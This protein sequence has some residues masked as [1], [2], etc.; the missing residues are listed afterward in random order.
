ME[1]PVD[2]QHIDSKDIQTMRQLETST[3]DQLVELVPGQK[4][5]CQVTTYIDSLES[6]NVEGSLISTGTMFSVTAIESIEILSFEFSHS[7]VDGD[8][9]IEIYTLA[10]SDYKSQR[11]NKDAWKLLSATGMKGVP[12]SDKGEKWKIAPRAEMKESVV[13]ASGETRSFY[14][15][16]LS[17]HLLLM[18]NKLTNSVYKED[19]KLRVNSG[20]GV[21]A[22][23][24][25]D[26]TDDDN[27]AFQGRI[28]YR[29]TA[30]CTTLTQTTTKVQVPF[31]V[32]STAVPSST[33]VY[34]TEF[35]NMI[36]T[37]AENTASALARWQTNDGLQMISF[38]PQAG[39]TKGKKK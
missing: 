31:V 8:L 20:I 18:E 4:E 11:K 15:S 29:S 38:S 32:D 10:G 3:P 37:A 16:L 21:R 6:T 2:S 36:K 27:L 35:E 17:Q 7:K 28:H 9:G 19:S 1:T 30:A 26:T 33:A 24:F 22:R 34:Q 14:F 13:M 23:N 12:S 5:Q 25:P 39:E